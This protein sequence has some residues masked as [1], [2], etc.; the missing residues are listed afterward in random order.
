MRRIFRFL[1]HFLLLA[2]I[3]AGGWAYLNNASFQQTTNGAAW[4]VRNRVVA[5]LANNGLI[6]KTD[7]QP[8][9]NTKKPAQAKQ[10]TDSNPAANGL[11]PTTGRW[12]TNQATVYVGTGNS[13]L[14][15]ATNSAIAAWNRTGA[16]NFKTT[17]DRSRADIVV[18]AM[19]NNQTAAAGLTQ[20]SFNQL[21]GRLA[22]A[23]VYLNAAYLTDP[24]YGYSQQRIV[25]T[26]EHELG[27]AIGL[28]HTNNTSV[29]QPVGSFYTIQPV[30]VQS[31]NH[32]YGND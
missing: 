10:Q 28:D 3:L 15:G 23:D 9:P 4:Q 27:H 24:N 2:V 6:T 11:D 16:F 14:D 18:Q 30:D 21:T 8:A 22:H 26:A 19:N 31:V 7:N 20:T 13:T 1:R 5:I 32:L 17:T 12:P 29:M 25:N